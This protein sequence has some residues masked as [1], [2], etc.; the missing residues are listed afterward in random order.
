MIQYDYLSLMMNSC[1]SNDL[2]WFSNTL[3]TLHSLSLTPGTPE[4]LRTNIHFADLRLSKQS[5]QW[6]SPTEPDEERLLRLCLQFKTRD[7][8]N[9][10]IFSHIPWKQ[11]EMWKR[12]HRVGLTRV[13]SSRCQASSA[14]LH[15]NAVQQALQTEIVELRSLW[16]LWQCL[17]Q[18]G[19][20]C[21]NLYQFAICWHLA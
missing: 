3:S 4:H 12:L 5:P 19:A 13:K 6:E 14:S 20:S 1:F 21:Y 9:L 15:L 8:L 2:P 10:L 17:C 18:C 11:A 16:I 7:S